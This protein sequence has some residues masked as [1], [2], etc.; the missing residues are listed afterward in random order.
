MEDCVI[1]QTSAQTFKCETHDSPAIQ[2][3][4][5]SPKWC[6]KALREAPLFR[7]VVD[8]QATPT[9][10]WKPAHVY[11]GHFIPGRLNVRVGSVELQGV[12]YETAMALIAAIAQRVPDSL[13]RDLEATL[14]VGYERN[15]KPKPVIPA[16]EPPVENTTTLLE[17]MGG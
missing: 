14:R 16:S 13:R 8:A 9:V 10:V 6:L 12:S 17:R 15:R 1:V 5:H 7:V 4:F 3:D 11:A 2:D